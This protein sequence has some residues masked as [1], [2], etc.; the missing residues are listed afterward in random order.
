MKTLIALSV[1][2]LIG[3]GV[4]ACNKPV[5]NEKKIETTTKTPTGETKTS[6]D[7]KTET[8]EKK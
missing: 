2:L 4:T 3:F 7:V 6:A 5:A 1:A 8:T